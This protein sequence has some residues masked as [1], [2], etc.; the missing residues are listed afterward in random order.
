MQKLKDFMLSEV[1]A[2]MWLAL[3]VVCALILNVIIFA[4]KIL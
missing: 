2:P 4:T 1:R 3:L